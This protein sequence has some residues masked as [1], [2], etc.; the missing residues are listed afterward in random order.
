MIPLQPFA[1]PPC[2]QHQGKER[3]RHDRKFYGGGALVAA[4][5][6]PGGPL[7]RAGF[8]AV[9]GVAVRMLD[10]VLTAT[11]WPLPQQAAE[12]AGDTATSSLADEWIDQAEERAWF[13]FETAQ[14][15]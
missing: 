6:P 4:V 8:E 7:D 11:V 13:L 15:A 5:S 10:N 1:Q 2:A 9:V 3:H 14:G 12:A